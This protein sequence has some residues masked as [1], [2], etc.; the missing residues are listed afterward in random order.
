[1]LDISAKHGNSGGP[2]I[3][4]KT[5]KVIGILTA[6]VPSNDPGDIVIYMHPICYLKELLEEKSEP[7]LDD[8]I[9]NSS[10]E[11]APHEPE[12]IPE[13]KPDKKGSEKF[14]K[15]V[16]IGAIAAGGAVLGAIVT[17]KRGK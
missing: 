7:E 2:L 6:R 17:S 1:M 14:W 4:C 8:E 9:D 10:G 5:G 12:V 13:E 16:K 15:W 11:L 3:S